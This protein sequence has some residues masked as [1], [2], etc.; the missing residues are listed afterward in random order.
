MGSAWH[1][2]SRIIKRGLTTEWR[3]FL[4]VLAIVMIIVHFADLASLPAGA[5]RGLAYYGAALLPMSFLLVKE[6]YQPMSEQFWETSFA[7]L[8]AGPCLFILAGAVLSLVIRL[9]G[10]VADIEVLKTYRF[11]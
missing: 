8:I 4:V 3:P 2:L 9:M 11:I 7:F 6:H 1:A 5:G 10:F